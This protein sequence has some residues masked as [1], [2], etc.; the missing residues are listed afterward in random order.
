MWRH[1]VMNAMPEPHERHFALV[2]LST[3][4]RDPRGVAAWPDGGSPRILSQTAKLWICDPEGGRARLMARI[5]CPKQVLS[6][7]SAWIV[8]W[9][10][11]GDYPSI[12]V[13]VRGRAGTTT[14]TNLLRWIL[15]VEVDPDTSRAIAVP[16][17][18]STA[19]PVPAIGPLRGGR[20][21]QVS[22][23]DTIRVRSDLDPEWRPRFRI[24]A[25]TGEVVAIR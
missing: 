14:D 17:V 24:D 22:A 5:P 4:S 18:P 9:D 3:Q 23:G 19:A 1:Q 2:V 20:E 11:I 8:G 12:Y 10:S 25:A 15:K 13:D 16:F 6:E 21:L 7:Y